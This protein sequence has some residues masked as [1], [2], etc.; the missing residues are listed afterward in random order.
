MTQITRSNPVPPP[1]RGWFSPRYGS[2][3]V[4]FLCTGPDPAGPRPGDR[5]RVVIYDKQGSVV[6]RLEQT[7][8]RCIDEGYVDFFG[9]PS[10]RPARYEMPIVDIA[11]DGTETVLIPDFQPTSPRVLLDTVFSAWVAA[12]GVAG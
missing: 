5:L 3:G 2:R 8:G 1:D 11:P 9:G 10:N 7:R 4:H 6:R 12:H